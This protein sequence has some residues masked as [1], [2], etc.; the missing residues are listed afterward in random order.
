MPNLFEMD[1]GQFGAPGFQLRDR[2]D[3]SGHSGK[4]PHDNSAII[5]PCGQELRWFGRGSNFRDLSENR[6]PGFN[7]MRSY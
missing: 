6:L 3:M 5:N 4:E 1:L 7:G 2:L